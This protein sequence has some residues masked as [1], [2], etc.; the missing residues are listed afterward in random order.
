VK[1]LGR[2]DD[3]TTAETLNA[4]TNHSSLI[5]DAK[6]LIPVFNG[7]VKNDLANLFTS[8]KVSAGEVSV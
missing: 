7:N 1:L 5:Y 2:T 4:S 8:A 6:N 3:H